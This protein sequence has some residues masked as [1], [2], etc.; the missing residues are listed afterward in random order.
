MVKNMMLQNKVAIVTG[1]GQGIGRAIARAFANHGANVVVNDINIQHAEAAA[2]EIREIGVQALVAQANV[3]DESMVKKMVAE[4]IKQFTRI[5]IL[6]NNAGIVLTGPLIKTSV[7]DW[8]KV[9]AV[10]LK[11]VFLCCREIFPVMMSQRWGRIINI[12]SVA[13]KRGGGLLGNS[14]YAASKGGVIAFTKSIAREGGP[15]NININAITPS[16]VDTD[17]TSGMTSV[18]R[19]T[20]IQMMPLGR[21]GKPEDIAS[22]A[23]FL[24][25]DYAAFITGEI[26][27]VDGGLMMD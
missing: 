3:T 4:C 16:L 13:G 19:D 17:M 14:S 23:C 6:V 8:D 10:N 1:A 15:Y 24:A 5:D 2:K 9:M 27:D 11:G 18:Q 22:A 12:A 21:A 25:S 20:V 26:M 7:A